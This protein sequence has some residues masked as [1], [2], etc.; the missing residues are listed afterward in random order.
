MSILRVVPPVVSTSRGPR[1]A[2]PAIGGLALLVAVLVPAATGARAAIGA[3]ECT[4]SQ[5]VTYTPGLTDQPRE[6]T[7]SGKDPLI[8][9]VSSSDPTIFQATSTFSATGTFS[10]TSGTRA[11]SRRITWN[12]GNTSTLSSTSTVSL[13]GAESLVLIKGVVVDGEFRGARWT[14]TFTMFSTK[15]QACLTAQGLAGVSGPLTLS[16]GSL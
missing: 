14:G 10:C 13:N 12:N 2:G 3:T 15:P 8:E 9:C 5:T 1:F 6:V 16:I 11:G 7:V 4:G